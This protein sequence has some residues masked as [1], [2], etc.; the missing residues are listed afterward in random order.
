VAVDLTLGNLFDKQYA[1]FLSRYREYALDQGRN[2]IVRV[3][4]DF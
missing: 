3:S 2:F 4:T 1:R